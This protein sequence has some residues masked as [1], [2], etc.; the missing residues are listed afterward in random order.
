MEE[1]NRLSRYLSPINVWALSFGCAVGWGAFVMP[2]TTF[3]PAAGPWGTALG[4]GIGA[5]VMLIIGMNYHYLMNKYPDAGGTLTYTAKTF[6]YD[7][8]FLSAWFILLVYIAIIWANATALTLIARNL[9]GSALQFGFHYTLLGYDVY[10]GEVLLSM[11]A[12]L[13][14]GLLCIHGKRLTVHIQTVLAIALFGGVVVC[15]VAVL[16]KHGGM[17]DLTPA[18][19]PTGASPVSQITGIIALS[20]WA[21]VG[22][23]SVS[24]S[25]AGFRFSTKKSIWIMAA[26]LLTG[27]LSYILLTWIAVGALPAGYRD[28]PSYIA[29]IGDLEG[30]AGLPTFYVTHEV[31]GKAG[32]IL[33]G[34]TTA[35]AIITGLVGNSIAASRLMYAMAEDGILPR[36]FGEL[37]EDGSPK[38]AFRFLMLISLFIPFVGRTA[39]GWIVDVNTIGA[40]IAY[41]YTSAAAYAS[42]KREGKRR[43]QVTGVIGIVMAVVFFFYFMSWSAGAMSTESYLILAFWSILG[44]V[45]FRYVF[46]KDESRRFGKST[47]VWIGL[48]FLIFF[49][50]LMWVKQATEDMTEDVIANISMYYESRNPNTDPNAI[51]DT[52]RYLAEQMAAANRMQTR[53]SIIQMGLIVASL[54]IMFSVYNIMSTREKQSESDK[55]RA[56]ESSKAK[57]VF[58][59]NM[60][61]DIRTP[62]NAIIGYTNLARRDG[63]GEAEMRE[64]LDK[65]D[66]S[67]HHLLAL[68][69]DVLEM[70][71]IESGKM[72]LEPVPVDLKKTF[73]EVRDMFATQMQE[74]DIAFTVDTSHVR[75]RGVLCDKNR[76]NRV[77]LNLLS[78]AYKFTPVGG[79]ISVTVWEIGDAEN[80]RGDYEIRV[81][82]S[83]I[84]MSPE[85]AAKVF[86]AFERERTS[87]VSGIQGTGLGMAIT[88]SIVDL[89]GGTI[90]VNTAP[91]AGTEFV[92]HL[93]FELSGDYAADD[94]Q[95]QSGS[96]PELD[97]S[98]L[99]L[100]LVEDNE[101]NREIA[102]MVLED[103]GFQLETAV[104][105]K[106]AVEK[107][108]AAQPGWFDAVLMDVQMP[109]M[110]GYEATRAIRALPDPALARIPIIA[111]TA[112]AFSE[113]IKAAQEAG[114]NAHVAKPLDVPNLL[115]TITE[116]VTAR[117]RKN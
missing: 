69:N 15:A 70:S 24:N 55:V 104:N 76:L 47:V 6:G 98:K 113:D 63:T 97:F 86:E 84:G 13:I 106:E 60:S 82:D 110:N 61:H 27:A 78:N 79:N 58:L 67:S 45:F 22:F 81:K 90:E 19:A 94:E 38:N 26:A 42:A 44:F 102:T 59:S 32:L 4:I 28:W 39:I 107:V 101:I 11:A 91:G 34:V 23:E 89:M 114:M 85:F 43:Y 14:F 20:P 50:S 68:T 25:T 73:A 29:D 83:G 41:G 72:D 7:H 36:W 51:A 80:G 54:S 52:E 8:G 77:L 87:T 103:A 49:T 108:S 65:I 100:L 117:E 66:S 116:Q 75:R 3:L 5:V 53:N 105:G 12:I 95:E 17:S 96:A 88:K 33:L 112:N 56:E 115:Q 18:F 9:L 64:Y 40:V 21:F 57:T 10:F 30:L 109:V 93:R 16:G 1:H 99:R 46:S 2:G 71:R 62:M 31:M 111:M 37:T 35:A 92:I 48:L 74:K